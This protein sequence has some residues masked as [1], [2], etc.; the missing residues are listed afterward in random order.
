MFKLV[1]KSRHAKISIPNGS[2]D[3]N[4]ALKVLYKTHDNIYSYREA[5]MWQSLR[6][7]FVL[8]FRGFYE[9]EAK[10]Q[11]FPVSPYMTNGTLTHGGRKQ[12]HRRWSHWKSLGAFIT[13]I[14]KTWFT[15]TSMGQCPPG[16]R[17]SYQNHRFWI[18]PTFGS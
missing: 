16:R 13:S 17:I 6:H 12:C 8:P 15:V 18:N 14:L 1:P 7:K 4:V 9:N 3:T 2:Y 11:F 5:L 10:L